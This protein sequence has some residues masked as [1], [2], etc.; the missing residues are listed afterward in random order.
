MSDTP[1]TATLDWTAEDELRLR[2]E[3]YAERL[4]VERAV[5]GNPS[6]THRLWLA[7]MR[8]LGAAA[9]GLVAAGFS[10]L[11]IVVLLN[12]F[13]HYAPGTS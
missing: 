5:F 11:A 10:I 12:L 1:E 3:V 13:F 8:V 6:L 4:G 9:I 2:R 7:L